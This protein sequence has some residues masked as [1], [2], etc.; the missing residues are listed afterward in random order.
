MFRP[1]SFTHAAATL[2]GVGRLAAINSAVEIDLTG[3]VNSEEAAGRRIGAVGGQVDF[4]RAAAAHG[5]KPILALPAKRIVT[6]LSGP[7]STARSDVDWVVTEHGARSL[8][9]LPEAA[10]RRALLELAGE[11]RAEELL[12]PVG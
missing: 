8:A 2:A 7:V 6:R 1:V 11:Q 10:R 4:L 3:Q 9:G 5:G 12:A